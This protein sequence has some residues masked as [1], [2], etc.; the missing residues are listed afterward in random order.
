MSVNTMKLISNTGEIYIDQ[1]QYKRYKNIELFGYGYLDWGRVIN[2]SLITLYDLIDNISD[3]GQSQFEFDLDNYQEEQKILRAEE[4]SIWKTEFKNILSQE[5]GL[6]QNAVD[7]ILNTF[8]NTIEEVKTTTSST[9]ASSLTEMENK[10]NGVYTQVETVIDQQIEISIRSLVQKINDTN[11]AVTNA[12]NLL[13]T[14]QNDLNS[15]VNQVNNIIVGFKD[16]FEESFVIFKTEVSE[17]LDTYRSTLFKY[18]D[19]KIINV[20]TSTSDLGTRLA[21]VESDLNKINIDTLDDYILNNIATTIDGIINTRILGLENSIIL[22]AEEILALQNNLESQISE[23]LNSGIHVINTRLNQVESQITI[24]GKNIADLQETTLGE[25]TEANLFIQKSREYFASATNLPREVILYRAKELSYSNNELTEIRLLKTIENIV[26]ENDKNLKNLKAYIDDERS[27]FLNALRNTQFDELSLI[28][29]R[30]SEIKIFNEKHQFQNIDNLKPTTLKLNDLLLIGNG[31]KFDLDQPNSKFSYLVIT[32]LIPNSVFPSELDGAKLEISINGRKGH[33]PDG[34]YKGF[35]VDY[36]KL[37]TFDSVEGDLFKPNLYPGFSTE[38]S[39]DNYIDLEYEENIRYNRN[40]CLT[41]PIILA[42]IPENINGVSIDHN[43]YISIK[44]IGKTTTLDT[45]FKIENLFDSSK[46]DFGFNLIEN[47]T[48]LSP[49]IQTLIQNKTVPVYLFKKS[50]LNTMNEIYLPQCEFV[51]TVNSTGTETKEFR[52]KINLPENSTLT[53]IVYD[54]GS[55]T[56][57]KTFGNVPF[58]LLK[59]TYDSNKVANSNRDLYFTDIQTTGVIKIPVATSV[60]TITGTINYKI[61]S[62]T[63]T[64]NFS[65]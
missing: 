27:L 58:N 10:V 50:E 24:L 4:F 1:Q 59:S 32:L 43:F 14:T 36:P 61:G 52:I 51:S 46:A 35:I 42:T 29:Q 2:Q 16:S 12:M 3:S 23:I 39:I 30:T 57:T 34:L 37:G 45:S 31:E 48:S 26:Q 21:K 15:T 5:I 22:I 17:T 33:K 25:L 7:E 19:D 47:K 38:E 63:K 8:G 55:G 13:G 11:L 54:L 6:Y 40:T 9:I 49:A 62:V 60:N 28:S 65:I 44:V 18:I 56:I 64:Y 41:S 20:G 53:N